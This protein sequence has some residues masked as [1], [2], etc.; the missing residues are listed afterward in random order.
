MS[1]PGGMPTVNVEPG[2]FVVLPSPPPAGPVIEWAQWLQ[3]VVDKRR[4]ETPQ[5]YEHAEIWLGDG[6]TA[7]AYP[8]RQ[9]LRPLS[10]T[11]GDQPGAL[12][13]SGL[14]TL[15]TAQR[16][17]IV[18]WCYDHANVQYASLDYVALTAHSLGMG[19][20]WLQRSIASQGSMICSQYVDAAYLSAGSHLFTDGRWPGF[21]T[22]LD[23]AMLLEAR[24]AAPYQP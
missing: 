3:Q 8:A 4:L 20:S 2:D 24:G 13:S 17:A 15:T 6:L 22:P 10:G 18:A 23:L 12:W 21:V 5:R 11:P 9:G 7:S 19:T 16:D 14:I 1:D